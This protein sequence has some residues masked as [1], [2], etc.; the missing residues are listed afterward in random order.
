MS[1]YAE[2]VTLFPQTE[3]ELLRLED[4]NRRLGE[5][6]RGLTGKVF[7]H[8]DT[9][10]SA[11][12]HEAV[13][14]ALG[15]EPMNF[16]GMSYGSQLGAQ[17]AELFPEN[18]RTLALDG[19]LQ[20]SQAEAANLLIE[21]SSYELGLSHFFAWAST[22]ESS[23]LKGQDV[24]SLWSE[25]L[26][27]ASTA[28][29][30]ALSCN[31][32]DCRSDVNDE[33]IRFNAHQYLT[34]AGKDIGLGSS[35]ELLASALYNATQGDATALSTRL[36]DPSAVSFLAIGCL[37]WT[38]NVS[39]LLPDILAQERMAK[40]YAPL[41]QG[42]SQ[43]WTLQHACLGW[44]VKNINPPTKLNVRTNATILL[45]QSTADPS[46]GLPWALGMLGEIENKVLV[47]R[48]GDGHT[49]LPLGG[50]TTEVIV[51]YLVT[52]RA[53]PAGLVLGS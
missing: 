37:D 12:D 21:A 20:H 44:P 27:N 8:L 24:R 41:T 5:S 47:L 28:P 1:I 14:I 52:G 49:S 25:L 31:D 50:R 35:W 46:T 4:K 45:T 40:E 18:I 6:C 38:H 9:V 51:E 36:T 30:P 19:I 10:S 2:R 17:Y 53:P 15:N 34:F 11:K 13:R 26:K 29:V 23:V 32:T 3:D 7:E 42:A 16:A 48:K 43:M 33:E 22:D 39:S